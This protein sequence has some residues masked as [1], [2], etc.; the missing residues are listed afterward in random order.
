MSTSDCIVAGTH[1]R[2]ISLCIP[3]TVFARQLFWSQP[4]SD[5]LPLK[6]CFCWSGIFRLFCYLRFL[7]LSWTGN[8]W[9][10]VCLVSVIVNAVK[11]W[12]LMTSA[13]TSPQVPLVTNLL[14]SG[15][16]GTMFQIFCKQMIQWW[17]TKKSQLGVARPLLLRVQISNLLLECIILVIVFSW[18]EW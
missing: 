8:L 13:P 15:G 5:F 7:N 1:W 9:F 12:F 18:M 2:Y 4:F 3:F 16:R 6:L 17:N 11:L 14:S 10:S